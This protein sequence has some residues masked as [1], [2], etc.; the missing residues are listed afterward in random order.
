VNNA[1]ARC[2]ELLRREFGNRFLGGF[3][4]TDFAARNYP[5]ALL[6]DNAVSAKENY[7][8]LLRAFPICVATTGL[9]GSIGWKMGEYV[10]FSR[11]IASERLNYEVPGNFMTGQ[12]YLEF[13]GPEACVNAVHQ[14]FSDGALRYA[15]MRNNYEYYLASLKPDT[16]VSRCIEIGLSQRTTVP[17]LVAAKK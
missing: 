17:C 10:A 2:I 16:M 4:H 9:H 15:M 11:A 3:I 14:L 7:L 1:R 5:G 12:N 6:P 13:T 8:K